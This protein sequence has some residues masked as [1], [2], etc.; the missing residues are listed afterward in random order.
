MFGAISWRRANRHGAFASLVVS[1]ALFFYLT[2]QDFGA[3]LRWDE[4]NF[5]IAILT[6]F[7]TLALVSLATK[8]EPREKLQEFYQ[9]LDSP[10]YL[11][12]KT[13]EERTLDE[14]GHDLHLEHE[15]ATIRFEDSS[16]EEL[17]RHEVA[18]VLAQH[19]NERMS[20]QYATSTGL[21]LVA[22]MAGA[23]S[24][25]DVIAF[26]KTQTGADLMTEAPGEVDRDQ[27][28]RVEQITGTG[29]GLANVRQVVEKHGGRIHV[30]SST[31]ADSHGTCF[32]VEIP[33]AGA[34]KNKTA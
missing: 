26:P 34:G 12:L 16:L 25:R 21:D 19:G 29:I 3:L 6:G 24:I 30:A 23:E 2:Y 18:H 31:A 10:S 8:P 20:T 28:Q 27:D 4:T 32:T 1:S 15:D 7:I 5:G 33:R 11:D 14:P 9:R 13:G 22:M 17:L